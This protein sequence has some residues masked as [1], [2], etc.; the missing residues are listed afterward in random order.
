[1]ALTFA[2]AP[3]FLAPPFP[4]ISKIEPQSFAEGK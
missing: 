4:F 2:D 1:M 3:P